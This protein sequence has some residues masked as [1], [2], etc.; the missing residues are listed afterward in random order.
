MR[1]LTQI[2]YRDLFSK[3]GHGNKDGFLDVTDFLVLAE[4]NFSVPESCRALMKDLS[5]GGGEALEL[6]FSD[7]FSSDTDSCGGDPGNIGI[8]GDSSLSFI[9]DGDHNLIQ[10]SSSG[11]YSFTKQL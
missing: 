6:S 10:C 9:F 2:S 8:A 7:P 3:Y 11:N 4:E 1:F 5:N